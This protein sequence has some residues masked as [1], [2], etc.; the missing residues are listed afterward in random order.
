MR[1]A[2]IRQAVAFGESPHPGN[3]RGGREPGRASAAPVPGKR[4]PMQLV[5]RPAPEAPPERRPASDERTP[6]ANE[7]RP[8]HRVGTETRPA[9]RAGSSVR[10][11]PV[12]KLPRRTSAS[13]PR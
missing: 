4:P 6:L 2:E 8:A 3:E 13:R 9:R 12:A 5:R 10:K 1:P 7:S 11:R